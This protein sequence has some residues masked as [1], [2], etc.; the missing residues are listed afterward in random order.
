[1]Q[2]QCAAI[3]VGDLLPKVV[4]ASYNGATDL[5]DEAVGHNDH[6]LVEEWE[7][8]G[9]LDS[10]LVEGG[11]RVEGDSVVRMEP[12]A[13]VD[14]GGELDGAALITLPVI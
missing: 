1:M 11:C 6:H 8:S 10:E 13:E 3:V 12:G 7:V 4:C 9:E 2:Q 14:V 5:L